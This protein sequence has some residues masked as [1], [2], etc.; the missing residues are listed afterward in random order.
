MNCLISWI[1]VEL[2][3]DW[4][5]FMRHYLAISLLLVASVVS[6]QA[7]QTFGAGAPKGD[8]SG[9]APDKTAYAKCCVPAGGDGTTSKP[10]SSLAEAEADKTWTKLQVMPSS[11][12]IDAMKSS[13]LHSELNPD[14]SVNT[15]T[16][17]KIE[18]P[19][20]TN[21]TAPSGRPVVTMGTSNIA[22]CVCTPPAAPG[23]SSN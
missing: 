20:T 15:T 9:K 18:P 8:S 22:D 21:S 4:G 16:P 17:V 13:T 11:N 3:L 19:K 6:A 2:F 7:P 10:F 23:T 5:G 12:D 14:G 1:K